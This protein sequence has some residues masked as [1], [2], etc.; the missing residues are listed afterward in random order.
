[1]FNPPPAHGNTDSPQE[2][3]DEPLT[4]LGDAGKTAEQLHG[5]READLRVF[6]IGHDQGLT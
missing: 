2:I 4:A 6:R 3:E 5:I 1:M